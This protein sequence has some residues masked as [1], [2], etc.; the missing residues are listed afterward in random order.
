MIRVQREK[1][2]IG[3]E[4]EALTTGRTDI[5]AVV[6]F[7]GLVR[8]FNDG[9]KVTGLS[10][11]HYPGM[12]ERELA[13]IEDEARGRWDIQEC[14]IIH[15]H[16][17]MALGEPIVLV[18]TASPHRRDAFEAAHFLMDWLKTKAPFW[19]QEMNA[20]G[21]VNWVNERES[22]LEAAKRWSSDT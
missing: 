2:D 8:D 3:A 16:G 14:L 18:V 21:E 9:N 13:K 20:S 22:D 19:K 17:K 15:R 10:L 1:F 11:E 12:T 7:T 4:I 5:G 6:S